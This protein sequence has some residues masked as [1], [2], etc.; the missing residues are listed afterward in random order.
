LRIVTSVDRKY[1]S[2]SAAFRFFPNQCNAEKMRNFPHASSRLVCNKLFSR[3]FYGTTNLFCFSIKKLTFML[4]NLMVKE[5]RETFDEI[6][7][8]P[9][10]A[11]EAGRYNHS[12]QRKS[13]QGHS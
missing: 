13:P 6:Q 1:L 9:T 8:I 2:L 10:M 4:Y 5:G 11:A 7:R 12:G 3:H